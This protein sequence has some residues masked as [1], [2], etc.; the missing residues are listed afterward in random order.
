M[1]VKTAVN[2]YEQQ[3]VLTSVNGIDERFIVSVS[4]L[5]VAE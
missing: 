2:M 1:A 5:S 3:G 4:D